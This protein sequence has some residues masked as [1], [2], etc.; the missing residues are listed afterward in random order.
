MQLNKYEVRIKEIHHCN[1]V[2]VEAKTEE[3]AR[4]NAKNMWDK[5]AVEGCSIDLDVELKQITKNNEIMDDLLTTKRF[6]QK[7]IE[8]KQ[9][10]IT[11]EPNEKIWKKE[12]QLYK[13]N[14]NNHLI[15]N[16]YI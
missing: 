15:I 4:D 16:V 1:V 3:E 13:T 11:D 2:E 14:E 10:Q 6:L 7:M 5:G 9:Q 12:K 8:G